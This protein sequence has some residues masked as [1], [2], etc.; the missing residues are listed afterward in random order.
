MRIAIILFSLFL[1]LLAF[2]HVVFAASN[3]AEVAQF[4][5]STLETLTILGTLAATFF[6]VKGGYLYITS[7]GKPEALEN[8]KKTIRNAAIGLVLILSANTLV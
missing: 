5:S 8:A 4:A 1:L 3:N 2:P 6:L 7:S